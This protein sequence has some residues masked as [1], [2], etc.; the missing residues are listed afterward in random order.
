MIKSILKGIPLDKF[1]W[2]AGPS[3]ATTNERM[4]AS[5]GLDPRVHV[6]MEGVV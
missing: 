1:A 3:P 2:M 6:F 5:R 4:I